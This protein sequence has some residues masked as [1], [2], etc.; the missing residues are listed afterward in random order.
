[1]TVGTVRHFSMA[2]AT[3][4]TKTSSL[5]LGGSYGKVMLGIPTMTSGTNIKV[6][7][8]GSEN[9]TYRDLFY[10]P[11]GVSAVVVAMNLNSSITQCFV[12]IEFGGQFMKVEF[13]TKMSDSSIAFDVICGAN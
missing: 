5:D 6:L 11:E 1:M 2:M 12:P 3:G 7:C 8:G 10:K 4:A 9:G 13:S